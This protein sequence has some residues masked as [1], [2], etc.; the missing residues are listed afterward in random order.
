M[1]YIWQ[2]TVCQE[3]LVDKV[4]NSSDWSLSVSNQE[5]ESGPALHMRC[6]DAA[7]KTK[8]SDSKED[9]LLNPGDINMRF[10]FLNTLLFPD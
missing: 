8:V 2:D 4:Y 9:A 10:F 5:V 7:F 1:P 6:N 3:T